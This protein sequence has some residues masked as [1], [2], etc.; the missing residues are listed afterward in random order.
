MS[1]LLALLLLIG[2]LLLVVCGAM[3][4]VLPLTAEGDLTLIAATPHWY[5]MHLAL[6]HATGLI[7]VGIW[8]RWLGAEPGERQGLVVA[9]AV[10]GIGQAFNGV[11]IAYMAG[12]GTRLAAM[13]AGGIGVR[14]VYQAT[15]GFAVVCGRWGGA[16]CGMGREACQ[17]GWGGV[18]GGAAR[19][20]RHGRRSESKVTVVCPQRRTYVTR[21]A[22]VPHLSW[23][24]PS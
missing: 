23:K 10:L 24:R 17:G 7:I 14:A 9:F 16:C 1:R 4:P 20:A 6:L 8:A 15:H 18:G 22:D 3:H 12:A 5:P 2:S 11:N 13:Q 19:P 21:I